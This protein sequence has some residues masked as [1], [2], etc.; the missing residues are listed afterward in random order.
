MQYVICNCTTRDFVSFIILNLPMFSIGYKHFLFIIHYI[1]VWKVYCLLP[2]SVTLS[3]SCFNYSPPTLN[4]IKACFWSWSYSSWKSTDLSQV[5]DELYH[6]M[7]YRVHLAM[8]R[9]RIHNFSGD[10]HWLH[11]LPTMAYCHFILCS[12]FYM[13]YKSL[14]FHYYIVCSGK[15][16]T[17]HDKSLR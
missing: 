1:A 15:I 5:T 17:Y 8:N 10:S 3:W 11:M 6:I 4:Y 16:E 9:V 12:V 2:S 13:Y 7:L 14:L